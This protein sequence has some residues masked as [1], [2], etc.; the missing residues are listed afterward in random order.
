MPKV[1]KECGSGGHMWQADKTD[2]GTKS[3]GGECVSIC[4]IFL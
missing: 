2:I 1:A 4:C 3:D